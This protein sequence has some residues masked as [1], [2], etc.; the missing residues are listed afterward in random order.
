M[1]SAHRVASRLRIAGITIGLSLI[2]ILSVRLVLAQ[3][4]ASH[5][6]QIGQSISGSLDATTFAQTYTF[7]AQARDVIT[8]TTTSKTAG[9][10]LALLL[11]G[12]DGN[13]L[14]QSA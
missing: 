5:K 2:L 7:D 8:I 1:A 9:L 6:I 11:A 13:M 10:A 3:N 4:N 12:S 14:A